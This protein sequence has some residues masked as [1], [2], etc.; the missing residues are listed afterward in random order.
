MPFES[1]ENKW[2]LESVSQPPPS[3]VLRAVFWA[4]SAA[5]ALLF[6]LQARPAPPTP[7]EDSSVLPLSFPPSH[8]IS[9]HVADGLPNN[10]MLW[11]LCWMLNQHL[12]V[13]AVLDMS[14]HGHVCQA[15]A[16]A[17]ST[18]RKLPLMFISRG[19]TPQIALRY[20]QAFTS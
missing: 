15:E 1:L 13:P 3:L 5:G 12:D 2:K 4:C 7:V 14:I 17:S 10:H 16:R 11:N 9:L 6:L 19:Y 8:A 20:I 18:R